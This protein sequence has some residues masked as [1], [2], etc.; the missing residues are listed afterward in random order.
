[1]L[2]TDLRHLLFQQTQKIFCFVFVLVESEERSRDHD[3]CRPSETGEIDAINVLIEL[4]QVNTYR[5][6]ITGE[7]IP[8]G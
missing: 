3:P 7:E 4:L 5:K 6:D 8:R 1:M 2:I